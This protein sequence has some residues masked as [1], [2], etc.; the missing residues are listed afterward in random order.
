MRIALINPPGWQKGS[1][2][3]G[4]SY[5]GAR[6]LADKHEVRIFDVNAS[7][8]IPEAVAEK[9]KKFAP[10]VI[11]FSVKTATDSQVRIDA[12]AGAT[13]SSRAVANAVN[14]ILSFYQ[15]Q[16]AEVN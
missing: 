8:M 4:L 5:L 11:G 15:Q 2:N 12:V 6:L 14:L 3:L 13:I 9:V 1:I 10:Q 16:I 7:E